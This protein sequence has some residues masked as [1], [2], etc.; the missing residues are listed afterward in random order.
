[1]SV[2]VGHA[3]LA[4]GGS[5]DWAIQ[6]P[7][8]DDISPILFGYLGGGVSSWLMPAFFLLS[9]YFTPR[10]FERKGT[11]QFLKD[12]LMRLGIPIVIVTTIIYNISEYMLEV[13]YR[14][15]PY[16]IKIV[17][18]PMHLWFL[19]VLLLFTVVYVIFRAL[20]DRISTKKPIQLYRD[21]FP[22][23]AILFLCIGILAIL[24]FAVRVVFPTG[25]WFLYV[26]PGY[27]VYYAFCFYG[28]VLAYR[29]DWFRRLSKAQARRWGIMSLGVI[30]LL[31]VTVTLEGRRSFIENA[32]QFSEFGAGGLHWQAFAFAV[33][34]T[35]L[36]V[37][38][39]AFLLHLFRERLNQAGPIARFA[40]TNAY[41]AYIIHPTI[42]F[43]VQILLLSIHI[44]TIVKSLLAA[45]IVVFLCFL[46]SS[47]IRRIPY[48]RQV[49]G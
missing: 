18:H 14:R 43:P 44:H 24:T 35:F 19:Q 41:T 31:V 21:T 6:D 47:P 17:Y 27:S 37:G 29:G 8:V 9:G 5:R 42:L 2:I 22:P 15:V 11:R 26:Q 10:S 46:L 28:G 20:A 25:V 13:H 49:L 48:A 36:M 33:W 23:D 40:A 34:Q 39:I 30:P 7:A 12:R 1:M 16:H 3:A 45:L 4:Y 32:V 38:I